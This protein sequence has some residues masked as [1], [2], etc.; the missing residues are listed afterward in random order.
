MRRSMDACL[1]IA[2]SLVLSVGAIGCA[3]EGVGDPCTPETVP[4]NS[5]GRECGYKASESYIEAS[6]VQ[7][8]SRL[9]IVHKLDNRSE[10]LVPADPR[11]ICSDR[12]DADGCLDPEDLQKSVYCTC[13]C[14]TGGGVKTNLELCDCPDGFTCTEILN[15]GGEGIIGSYCTKD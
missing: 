1:W 6:S 4:C 9:C 15:L 7:C 8:R 5:A 12:N 3:D 14:K 2:L 10:G 13:R 11:N